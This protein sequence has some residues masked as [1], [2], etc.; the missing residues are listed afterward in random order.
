MAIEVAAKVV[1]IGAKVAEVSAKAA[2][3]GKTAIDVA[4]RVDV[5]KV[6]TTE[7]VKGVDISK[8]VIPKDAGSIQDISGSIKDYI[9]DLRSKSKFA[10]TIPDNCLDPKK[11]E[12]QT[13][14]KV[15]KLR[16]EFDDSKAKLR[17]EWEE[18]NHKEWPRYTEQDIKDLNLTDRKPGDRYDAHHIQPLQLGGK[19]EASNIT[20]MDKKAHSELHSN[21]GSCKALVDKV[22]SG[23]SIA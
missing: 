21:S 1:E 16:D 22:V 7:Q 3:T 17:K 11:I 20:P 4:K 9:S 8:R 5:T 23:R 19:N 2:E 6:I 13:P 10:D 14:D 12:F 18:L 15:E